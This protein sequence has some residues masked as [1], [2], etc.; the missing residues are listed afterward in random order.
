MK[1]Y[2]K[3]IAAAAG[4]VL[5]VTSTAALPPSWAPWTALAGSIA[6]VVLVLLGPANVPPT[7]AARH[8]GGNGWEDG[9]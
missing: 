2:R 4:G 8:A 3:A 6:T 1:R 5:T 9:G 7:P